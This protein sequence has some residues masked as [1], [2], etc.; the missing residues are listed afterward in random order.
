MLHHQFGTVLATGCYRNQHKLP[1]ATIAVQVLRM[2]PAAV[3]SV[4]QK[5]AE[6]AAHL[7]RRTIQVVQTF[8]P[9]PED[10]AAA[11]AVV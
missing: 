9:M 4:K 1:C 5:V 7:N 2:T 8:M 3:H 6:L 10:A 11:P